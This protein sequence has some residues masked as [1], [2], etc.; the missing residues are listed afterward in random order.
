LGLRAFAAADDALFAVTAQAGGG[1]LLRSA[2]GISWTH[3]QRF[4][5]AEPLDVAVY[6]GRLYVGTEGP[7]ARGTLW[8]PP[9]PAP[10][11]RPIAPLGLAREGVKRA[12]GELAE[13]LAALD[14]VLANPQGYGRAATA[15][16]AAVRPLGGWR[17]PVAGHELTRRLS[18][19]LLEAEISMFGGLT[20]PAARIARWYLLWALART[21]FGRVP[22]ELLAEPWDATESRARKYFFPV[23]AAAWVVAEL[24]QADRATL[25]ALIAR[26][27]AQGDPRWL[28]GDVLG[29]L[30]ALTGRRF[31]YDLDAWRSWWRESETRTP[32]LE[33]AERKP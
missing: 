24:G 19:P 8:G 12:P 33:E 3:Q 2:D 23:S 14:G 4:E 10:R 7:D 28:T 22:P 1:A 26:L 16:R 18:G 25:A 31:G 11:E 13:A 32:A 29:A 21:G 27:D 5:G 20:L 9:P 17:T 6:A 15:L 30:T